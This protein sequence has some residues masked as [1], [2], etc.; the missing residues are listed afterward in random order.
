[1]EKKIIKEYVKKGL[2]ATLLYPGIVYGPGDFNIF[3]QML[4]D[5]V[6][7]KFLGCPGKGNA[8]ACFTYVNDLVDIMAKIIDRDDLKGENFILGGEN[9]EFG[10]YLNLIAEI[11]GVKKPSHFPMA[12]AKFYG[13]LCEVNASLTKKMPY[14]TRPTISA[15]KCNREYSSKKAIEELGYKITPLRK[16]LTETIEW[17]KN[18]IEKEK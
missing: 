16:G 11:A 5:I 1:M 15:I 4:F 18:F 13:W 12:A 6:R 17:Y 9:I 8:I 10:E 3:G 14:I 7:G 2:N